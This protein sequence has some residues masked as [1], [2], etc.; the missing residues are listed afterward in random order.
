MTLDVNLENLSTN[1]AWGVGAGSAELSLWRG[2]GDVEG[3][4]ANEGEP[5]PSS[6]RPPCQQ[7]RAAVEPAWF[8]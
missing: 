2:H 6:Q 7:E 5:V 3:S 4:K 1:N 8:K